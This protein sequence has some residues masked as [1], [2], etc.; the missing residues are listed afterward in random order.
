MAD[1]RIRREEI[2]GIAKERKCGNCQGCDHD[3]EGI[4]EKEQ[5]EGNC[6]CDDDACEWHES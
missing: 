2:K 6:D 4:N 1:V 5:C 3:A